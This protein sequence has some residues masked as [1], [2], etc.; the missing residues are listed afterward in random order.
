LNLSH[1]ADSNYYFYLEL[2]R[3]I[4]LAAAKKNY[5]FFLPSHPYDAF[6]TIDD[7]E[8][9]YILTLQSRQVAG[10]ITLALNSTDP[11]I[12]ALCRSAI[13]AVFI[14]CIYQG[15]HT[16][17]VKSDFV[18]GARQATTHLLQLGHRRIAFFPGNTMDLTGTERLLGY[19]QAMAQ[20]GLIIDTGL[21]RQSGWESKDAYQAAMALLSERR[22]FTA[23]VAGSD[24]M[25]IGVLR[26]LRKHG[27]RVPEDIS[28]IGFDDIDLS[29]DTDP[30]LT[31]IRQNKQALS[32]GAVSRLH[33]LLKGEE[34]PT[35]LIVPTQLI[36]RA[37]TAPAPNE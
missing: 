12:Q 8:S 26:A 31:T 14:D 2:L 28:L 7:L 6:D 4:E 32:E 18:D 37:S 10:V 35:P 36:V 15:K 22:D 34:A 13:P 30:P 23:I 1:L 21:M 5:D 33:Q 11:R 29:E 17:Y 3:F 20:A 9:R 24:M 16:T 19:Q 27:L 25:A